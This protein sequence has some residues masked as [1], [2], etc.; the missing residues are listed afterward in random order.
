MSYEENFDRIIRQKAEEAEYPFD[1]GN[2]DKASRMLD[3]ERESG[4]AFK[5]RKVYAPAAVA[6][7]LGT[8]AFL[9]FAYLGRPD[10]P[11]AAVLPEAAPQSIVV[12][13]EPSKVS[14]VISPVAPSVSEEKIQ[15]QASESAPVASQ[16]G[17][18]SLPP[19]SEPRPNSPV[20]E[21]IAV[22]QEPVAAKE[23]LKEEPVASIEPAAEPVINVSV[24]QPE[25]ASEE[26]VVSEE[27]TSTTLD[28]VTMFLP[29]EQDE[30]VNTANVTLLF[31]YEDY[32]RKNYKAYWFALDAGTAYAPGWYTNGVNDAR[33]FNGYAGL[34]YGRYFCDRIGVSAGLEAYNISNINQPLYAIEGKDYSFGSTATSTVV[35]TTQLFYGAVPLK[36][37]YAFSRGN[38]LSA[39][40]SLGW[41]MC[42][43]NTIETY[44]VEN[45]LPVKG[46]TYADGVYEG[47]GNNTQ[48]SLAYRY[49]AGKRVG[50]QAEYL[51]GVSDLFRK[52]EGQTQTQFLRVGIQYLFLDK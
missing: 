17:E 34:T 40:V 1:A 37:H 31:V 8:A 15:N 6:V 13:S 41:A 2:W 30:E 19:A 46:S 42:G 16:T 51:Y 14:N 18:R 20:S 3:K 7:V 11:V 24:I 39:G 10:S 33:S 26:L 23:N 12:Q 50:L 28:G 48:L 45:D 43:R 35:T 27:Q 21:P 29:Y 38:R 5:L 22:T 25:T 52:N 49:M 9:T 4:T 47:V 36:V 32:F 44:A